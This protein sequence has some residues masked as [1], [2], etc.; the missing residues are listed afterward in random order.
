MASDRIIQL[1]R[2]LSDLSTKAEAKAFATSGWG[3]EKLDGVWVAAVCTKSDVKFFSSTLEEYISLSGTQLET[4]ILKCPTDMVLI[5]EA[6]HP[7]LEQAV[8]SGLCRKEVRGHA[9]EVQFH[10]HDILTTAEWKDMRSVRRYKDRLRQLAKHIT[11]TA[12]LKVIPQHVIKSVVELRALAHT[13]QQRGGEGACYRPDD[14]GWVSGDRG[15]NLIRDKEKITFDL[16]A[17]GVAGVATG[18]KGGLLGTLQV[19][20]KRGGVPTGEP[21]TQDI[22]GM[23]HDELRAWHADPSLI[24]GKIVQVEAMK[25]TAY[26]MLREP[27]F[28]CVREDK[29]ISDLEI[30]PL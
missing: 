10:C 28:K 8:V 7:D 20:W 6:Y 17:I 21:C 2:N 26:G 12:K 19:K 23:S 11:P 29:K 16:E 3:S 5:G 13:I 15:T 4:D 24:A 1:A 25:F 9:N 30:Q 27:R 18:P 14:A 22:R